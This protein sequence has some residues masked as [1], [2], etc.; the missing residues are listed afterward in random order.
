[1][2]NIFLAGVLVCLVLGFSPKTMA[3]LIITDTYTI[4]SAQ[5]PYLYIVTANQRNYAFGT[6]AGQVDKIIFTIVGNISTGGSVVNPTA[7]D[8][9]V[10]LL[11]QTAT[12]K[13]TT[14]A[15][16]VL[17]SD[18]P[19][20]TVIN[21]PD[22]GYTVYANTTYDFSDVT[23]TLTANKT[24]TTGSVVNQ[25]LGTG[26][27]NVTNSASSI[28]S[29]TADTGLNYNTTDL[30]WGQFKVSYDV[31]PEP[32]TWISGALLLGVA[33][34]GAGRSLWRKRSQTAA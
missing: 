33:G 29:W 1:M 17:L 31:V 22:P 30:I 21:D 32:G 10:Y 13:A 2:R 19:V 23:G 14:Q 34:V 25:F 28:S 6:G 4:P 20:A 11:A 3:N 15:G 27:V 18:R 26:T 24:Y 7:G 5:Q 9:Q 12:I 16:T 8:L